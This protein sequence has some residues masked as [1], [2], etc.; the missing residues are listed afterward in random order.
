MRPNRYSRSILPNDKRTTMTKMLTSPS[1]EGPYR[2]SEG[3]AAPLGATVT[4]EGVNFSLY[5]RKAFSVELLLFAHPDDAAP[6]QII[7]LDPKKNRSYHYWHVLVHGAGE[8]LYY[9]YRV[10]GDYLP[11]EGLYFDGSKLLTDPFARGLYG[12]NYSRAQ[13]SCYGRDNLA[14]AIK[15]VVV[16]SGGYD[17]EG[18]RH[19]RI[20]LSHSVIYEMHV[21]GFTAHS[22]AGISGV[23]PGTFSAVVQKIP[24][25]Q[26]LGVTAVELM[27]VFAFDPQ[28]APSGLENYWGYSPIN[29]F[30]PH[31]DY[32]TTDDPLQTVREFRDMVKAFHRAGMEVI[33]DV[34]Y[35]HTAES[36][37]VGPW[38][39]FKGQAASV[40]YIM[41]A[42]R[43][44]FADYTG[45]GNTVNTNDPILRRVLRES[46]RYWVDSMHVDGFRFDLAAILTRGPEGNV[47]VDSPALGS[48]EVDPVLSDTKLI[49]EAWDAAG[50]YQLGFFAGRGRDSRW[51]EWNGAYRDDIRRFVRGDEGMVPR[52]AARIIG[53]PDIYV[54]ATHD[55]NQSIHFVSCHDGFTLNDLVTYRIKHNLA[56]GE[57]NRDGLNENF[58]ANYGVEGPSDDPAVE[59]LRER[60]VRNFFALLLFT[61][62]TPMIGMGDEVRRTQQGN[63]NAY[64][65]DNPLSWF[66]WD[67]PLRHADTLDFVRR[68]IGYVQ[69]LSLY[70]LNR[71][72]Q[73]GFDEH[74][75]FLLW[76]GP[77]LNNA[78]W[79]P[80]SH[81]LAM[82][83]FHPEKGEHLY[84]AFNMYWGDIDFELPPPVRGSWRLVA[85]TILPVKEDFRF[86]R[87]LD[88][89]KYT[90]KARSVLIATDLP[91]K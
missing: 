61:H 48:I 38:L 24:Y 59:A 21:K 1:Q 2:I 40:Y 23:R 52:L 12:K 72:I 79:R 57:D 67:D 75:P 14:T 74:K 35:N 60:Q 64:C 69:G 13:A 58:S 19:P 54:D 83:M 55:I 89:R 87:L 91:D 66:D 3:Q 88:Q 63:N 71:L 18:D 30:A 32:G 39:N 6:C 68:L 85:D 16:G 15:S 9:G 10:Y 28:D 56:N 11:G 49:A 43:S 31:W 84:L 44:A 80:I 77:Q 34:V 4:D 81:T 27:P 90:L 86:T 26:S 47:L 73:V 22:N 45:C 42:D 65:Q 33:L 8:G 37:K 78:D 41:T 5:T 20:P 62:G 25:L 82:E 50:L 46:L 76:H 70:E 51:A 53:S 36:G 7:R 17:W 29:F